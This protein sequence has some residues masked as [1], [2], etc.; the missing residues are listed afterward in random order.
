MK[1]T[2]KWYED[3]HDALAGFS[4]IVGIPA[5]ILILGLLENI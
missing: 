3:V 4:L 2:Q 1:H 5:F